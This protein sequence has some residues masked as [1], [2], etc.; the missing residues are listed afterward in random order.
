[1]KTEKIDETV[2]NLENNMEEAT[3]KRGNVKIKGV[4]DASELTTTEGRVRQYLY[5]NPSA[6]QS[7]ITEELGVSIHQVKK[8]FKPHGIVYERKKIANKLSS[9][10]LDE[11]EIAEEMDMSLET[12]RNYLDSFEPNKPEPE[13]EDEDVDHTCV[14]GEEFDNGRELGGHHSHCD[15]Y[16]KKK[17]GELDEEDID[18]ED[19]SEEEQ[20]ETDTEVNY[21]Y[22]DEIDSPEDLHEI[23]D[24]IMGRLIQLE[25]DDSS[26]EMTL[27]DAIEMVRKSGGKVVFDKHD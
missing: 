11:D 10:G 16:Q 18:A 12:V 21:D 26:D 20:G 4:V 22:I 2:K 5:N 7:E 6:T 8:V 25:E 19:S 9:E 1:M 15:V 14:C 24:D 3:T 17:K 27:P 13:P 23:L